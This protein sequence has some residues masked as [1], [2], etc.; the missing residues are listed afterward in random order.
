MVPLIT[1]TLPASSTDCGVVLKASARLNEL[2]AVSE[3]NDLGVMVEYTRTMDD[4]AFDDSHAME[5]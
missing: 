3:D 5:M 1:S 2:A 4:S